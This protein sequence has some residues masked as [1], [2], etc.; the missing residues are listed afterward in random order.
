MEVLPSKISGSLNNRLIRCFGKKSAMKVLKAFYLVW[1]SLSETIRS[2][3]NCCSLLFIVVHCC[4][5]LLFCCSQRSSCNCP[6]LLCPPRISSLLLSTVLTLYLNKEIKSYKD[7][8]KWT[9]EPKIFFN[10]KHFE[11]KLYPMLSFLSFSYFYMP[12]FCG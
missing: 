4:C 1:H 12:F 7:K 6:I 3:I 8:S 11:N 9:T 10:M 5:S 2:I